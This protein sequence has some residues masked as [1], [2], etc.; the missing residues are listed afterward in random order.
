METLWAH[1]GHLCILAAR[2]VCELN[3]EEAGGAVGGSWGLGQGAVDRD[4]V[5]ELG[6]ETLP[7]G[8][9]PAGCWPQ[10]GSR[11]PGPN[12]GGIG[13]VPCWKGLGSM[14][15]LLGW[16]MQTLAPEWE[17]ILQPS[18]PAGGRANSPRL[19]RMW[20]EGG[21]SL[22]PFRSEGRPSPLGPQ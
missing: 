22:L 9:V 5:G 14:G 2:G 17:N 10:P 8:A 3:R 21:S 1:L 18:T 11:K 15:I 6:L 7:P 12:Q 16:E 4:T 13:C 20:L 19:Y